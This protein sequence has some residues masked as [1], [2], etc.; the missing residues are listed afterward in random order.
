MR[1]IAG[2]LR[3]GAL[4]GV[5][6]DAVARAAERS[7]RARPPRDDAGRRAGAGRARRR[8]PKATPALSRFLLQPF[9]PVQPML[10]D[11]AADVDDAL[12]TLGEASLEYKLDGARIQVHKADDE[13]RVFSRNLRDVTAA[14]PE[15]VERRA[16]AARARDRFSTAKSIALRPDGT[17]HPFQITMRR[18]GRKLDVE[19]LRQ[20][21]PLH[22]VLLRL[23]VSRRRAADRRAARPPRRRPGRSVV[24]A[25]NR[26]A[27]HRHREPADAAARSPERRSPPVTKA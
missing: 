18:F 8:S 25:A 13:V 24:P 4:E 3:Q 1:L 5:L 26:R 27:A 11:S 14:V 22:A 2:E 21:L 7:G 6:V 15:V 12:T 9:Q 17:P 23:P 19:R 16:G 10:A 20:E